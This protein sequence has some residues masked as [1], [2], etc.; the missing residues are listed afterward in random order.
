VRDVAC[1]LV[2]VRAPTDLT[3]MYLLLQISRDCQELEPSVGEQLAS[4]LYLEPDSELMVCFL[5]I[6]FGMQHI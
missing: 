4:L 6:Y 2:L 1:G 3:I 5:L